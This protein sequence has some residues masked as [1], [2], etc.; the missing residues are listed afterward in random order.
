MTHQVAECQQ[1][2]LDCGSLLH[3]QPGQHNSLQPCWA[4]NT[5][6]HMLF[7]SH[8]SSSLSLFH[9][10]W[11]GHSWSAVYP[12]LRL[13]C[14]C[15]RAGGDCS[16][17]HCSWWERVPHNWCGAIV[18]ASTKERAAD[19]LVKGLEFVY[20]AECWQ[21]NKNKSVIRFHLDLKALLVMSQ[22]LNVFIH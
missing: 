1:W 6:T 4:A 7:L 21:K 15:H 11:G 17:K 2:G 8:I 14:G 19:A 18:S 16:S 13:L 22:N 20:H 3:G 9:K 5:H 12:I 10:H